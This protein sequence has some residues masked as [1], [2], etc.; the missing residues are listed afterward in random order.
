MSAGRTVSEGC[1]TIRAGCATA[2]TI[3]DQGSN[4]ASKLARFLAER[5][6]ANRGGTYDAAWI[7]AQLDEF[8]EH[9]AA[10]I[11]AFSNLLLEPL[12]PVAR[13]VL[14]AG[15]CSRA[16]A[17]AF[18][19]GLDEPQ[20]LWPWIE[21]QAEA[22]RFAAATAG[23]GARS[24]SAHGGR[25]ASRRAGWCKRWVGRRHREEDRDRGS[26]PGGP[27]RGARP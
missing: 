4:C 12:G 11:T 7:D 8:W 24:P 18:F 15:S 1:A 10:H 17:A 3:A 6:D 14:L 16:I 2:F 19:S 21:D 25:S 26:G 27:A 13:D 22:R 20:R 23:R 9:D 5:I